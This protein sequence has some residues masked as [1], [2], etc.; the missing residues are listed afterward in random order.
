[1]LFALVSGVLI[2]TSQ[3]GSGFVFT[4]KCSCI[5]LEL[6]CHMFVYCL[7]ASLGNK[8]VSCL[9]VHV[10][11]AKRKNE[12]QF[13]I[14]SS[15]PLWSV[16]EAILIPYE[17]HYNFII[18]QMVSSWLKWWRVREAEKTLGHIMHDHLRNLLGLHG[19]RTQ[20]ARPIGTHLTVLP[21]GDTRARRVFFRRILLPASRSSL[22]V[23]VMHCRMVPVV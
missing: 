10:S 2:Y 6:V 9:S 17:G 11:L 23:D 20:P 3:I 14:S 15:S 4:P 5:L 1:M 16:N 12:S 8:C 7:L 18:G 21:A 22:P 19:T 13:D